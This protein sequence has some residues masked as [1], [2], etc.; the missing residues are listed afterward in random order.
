MD[1]GEQAANTFGSSRQVAPSMGLDPGHRVVPWGVGGHF[2]GDLTPGNSGIGPDPGWFGHWG[3]G[4]GGRRNLN[5]GGDRPTP[6]WY[7]WLAVIASGLSGVVVVLL[8]V[9][10]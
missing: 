9:V 3:S 10:R 2:F 1:M 4:P 6:V 7:R 8:L 5:R